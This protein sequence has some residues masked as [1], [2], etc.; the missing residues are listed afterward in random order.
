MLSSGVV[1][2][3]D[4]AQPAVD[5]A[6][7]KTLRVS[8]SATNPA[9]Q[10]WDTTHVVYYDPAV[11]NNKL[12]LWMAGTNGT[13][14]RVPAALF[15][16][17]LA[18]GYR[19]IALSYIT[20]PAVARVCKEGALDANVNC[21]EQ[22]RRQRVYGNGV[23]PQIDDQAQ[24]AI[25]PRFVSLL[26]WLNTN[27]A[28]GMWS[29]YLT[30]DGSTANWENVALFGQSQGGGMAQFIGQRENVARVISFSG[31]WDYSNSREKK[32]ASWY[33][34]D[35]VTPLERWFATYHVDENAAAQL[36][37]IS[38]ALRIPTGQLFALDKPLRSSA[39]TTS[40]NP[41]HGDGIRNP[42]YRP[43]WIRMFGSGTR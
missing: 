42:V 22:F 33:S 32:I 40:S 31:G 38:T 34:R 5:T 10:Q 9:I 14:L 16:T 12:L 24:D 26:Q 1:E 7:Y 8:P 35:A 30:A 15:N 3:Q 18:Q 19:V 39:S 37:E 13:P 2:A 27:D 21:A 25:I 43:L 23:F 29:R 4:A 28:A 41:Y 20:V 36:L 6:R 11:R 17:A